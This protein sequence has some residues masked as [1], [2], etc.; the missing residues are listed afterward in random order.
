[1]SWLELNEIEMDFLFGLE[2]DWIGGDDKAALNS[3]KASLSINC[4]FR[5]IRKLVRLKLFGI[6]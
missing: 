4:I 3:L 2:V 5:G 6:D 1:M